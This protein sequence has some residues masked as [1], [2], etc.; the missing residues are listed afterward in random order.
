MTR[1]IRYAVL[2]SSDSG[3]AGERADIGG[4]AVVS[5]M[6][7]KGYVLMQRSLLPDDL[8][9][10]I[11]QLQEWADNPDVDLI[12]TTGGKGLGPRGRYARSHFIGNRL[13]SSGHG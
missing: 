2:T 8:E 7:N 6:S 5:S 9:G 10:L 13:P 1:G 3:H 11:R 4:D 12:L